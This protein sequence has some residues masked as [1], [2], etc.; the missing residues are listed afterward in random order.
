[1]GIMSFLRERAGVIIVFAIGLAIVAFLLSDVVRSGKGFIADAQSE[2][3]IVAGQPINY[4]EFNERVEQNSQQFKAQMGSLNPQM[5]SYVVENSWNQFTSKIIMDKQT[6][7]I[8]L[9]VSE[10]ELFD[11]MFTNPTQQIAQIFTDPKTGQFNRTM[12]ITS[13]KSADTDAKLKE[14]WVALENSI[15]DQ[16]K[17]EK[18]QAL[19]KNGFYA[20]TL[21]AKD[22][23]TNRNKLANFSYVT[24]PY[25]NVKDTEIKV[26]DADYEAYYSENKYRFDNKTETRSFEY[27]AFDASPSKTDTAETKA[28]INKIAEG[29]KTTDNDSL[30]IAINAETTTPLNFVKK[31]ALDPAIDSLMFTAT[32][33]FVY[34]P[35]L[36]NGVY[37]VAKLVDA[38]ISPDSVKARHILLDP[39]ALGGVDIAMA[40]ADSIKQLLQK[41]GNF[42]ALAA[43][44]STDGSKDKGGDLGTFAR[45]AMVPAFEDAA[46]GGKP[47][48]ISI[49]KTQFGVHIIDI[50]K[51]IGSSKVVK[52]AL[53]DKALAPSSK[54]EQIAYQKAQSFLSNAKDTAAFINEAKA[55]GISKMVASDVGP[56]QASIPGLENARELIRWAF[57]AEKADVSNEIFDIGD[58]Y[59]I[60]YLT[61]I[62]PKG[63]LALIDVKI[64]IENMVKNRVKAA[65]LK[66]K[67]ETALAGTSSLNQVAAKLKL[68]VT[69]LSN[70]VFANPV[71]PGVAQENKLIG[72]VFGAKVNKLSGVIEGEAG[73][74]V[75]N[76]NGFTNSQ[77]P[78]NYLANKQTLATALSNSA[79]SNVFKAL[80]TSAKIT[81]N[82]NKFY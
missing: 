41:G 9:V 55:N 27:V 34:G 16:R 5:M 78:A 44:F 71:I 59:V 68:P 12:A 82:R 3:G 25:A 21:D 57:K 74:Y 32:K 79:Q 24:M 4:K 51:Q 73:I 46:F 81:D 14:Q 37:K 39:T 31:G 54:T 38:K 43:Q 23:F 35:Y 30:Y 47:G 10:Q 22:D 50:Q 8:G 70:I 42:A 65:Y 20:N 7:K 40:K 62:K 15:L 29:F 77:I 80:Q 52:V 17:S 60:A 66:A 28:K 61:T 63:T 56:L 13:R 48:Q 69:P 2:V 49:I 45:G 19:L 33:G 18:F 6:E 58:K 11:L 64:Q 67:L 76:L 1:M 36:I 26:T 72:S 53:I 75:Y